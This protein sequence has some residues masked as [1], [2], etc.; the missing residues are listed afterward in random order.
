MT[1]GLHQLTSEMRGLFAMQTLGE[2]RWWLPGFTLWRLGMV[3]LGDAL[4]DDVQQFFDVGL[5]SPYIYIYIYYATNIYIY[6]IIHIYIPINNRIQPHI[7]TERLPWG[8]F[9]EL[10]TDG[11][12][13]G[14][15]PNCVAVICQVVSGCWLTII[16]SKKGRDMQIFWFVFKCFFC[17]DTLWWTNIAMENGHL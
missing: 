2:R 4:W 5:W 15:C 6:I 3:F 13:V 9:M 14:N 10:T 16:V 7:S 8:W 12:G 11:R 17:G 1:R